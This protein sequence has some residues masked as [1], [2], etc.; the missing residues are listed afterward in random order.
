MPE[1]KKTVVMLTNPLGGYNLRHGEAVT[2]L[3]K[4][5]G[6]RVFEA[7]DLEEISRALHTIAAAEPDLLIVSGGDGT[8]SAVVQAM[9][10]ERMFAKEPML[11]LLRGGSTNM[12]QNDVGLKGKPLG[13]MRRLI[14]EL[15][16]D[17][18]GTDVVSRAPLCVR[19]GD[20][21]LEERG[22]FWAAG[23][24]PRVTA[25]TQAGYAEGANR[26]VIGESFALLGVMKSL[27]L[28]G[29]SRDPRL[30][31]SE[32][33]WQREDA[34]ATD[35]AGKRLFVFVTTL[36]RLILRLVPG[37][38]GDGL[39]LVSLKHPHKGGD[40]LSYLL[41]RGRPDVNRRSSSSFEF[42]EGSELALKFTGDW[43][44]DGEFF[45]GNP[46]S[47]LLHLRNEEPFQFLRFK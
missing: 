31:P 23:A 43:V 24:L 45:K 35:S 29:A 40:L 37:G 42:E 4:E 9:R 30:A 26:G 44:L 28:G 13:A 39:K 25:T 8:V 21:K 3:A 20:G 1:T 6:I 38:S 15:E 22:F 41:A 12:I 33:S 7:R 10:R 2:A 32:I 27:L 17:L 5:A 47:T 36:D 18:A 34:A 11:A 46:D 16:Q 19:N 14:E